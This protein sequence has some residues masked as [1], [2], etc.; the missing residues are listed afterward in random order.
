MPNP[1]PSLDDLKRQIAQVDALASQGVLSAP[2]A[3]EARAKL[4]K[5]L[6]EAVTA[7]P[8][9]AP[10][11]AA[12]VPTAPA[13]EAAPRTPRRL[14]VGVAAFVVVFA[15]AGYAWR[16]N[17]EGWSVGP[18][19]TSTA[20]AGQ[21]SHTVTTEQIAAMVGK[22]EER[23]KTQPDDADGWSMLGRT[24]TALNRRDEAL[25]AFRKVVALRPQDAQALAD[26]ADALAVMNGRSLDGEPEKLIQQAVKLDPAN[27][28]ALALAGTI[29]FNRDD[30]KTA[31][32]YW[33]R[34]VDRS[35]PG[36]DFA[37]QLQGAVA[38]ARQRAGMAPVA[39]AAAAA[40]APSTAAASGSA[41]SVVAGAAITGRVTLSAALKDKVAPG[42]S[43]FIFARPAT[44]ARMPLAILR[45]QAGEL[46]L[47]FK[48]DDSLAMSP[49]A[50]LS[51][52][53]QVI[54]GARISK[55]G[56]AMPQ[57]GDLQGLSQ[58]VAVGAQGVTIEIAETVK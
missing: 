47:E 16:G 10:G 34:A 28:K 53:Q 56:N 50:R 18:G 48:L 17:H 22:L 33:Q 38:E 7:V 45:K 35:E 49:A 55:S 41:G 46:P 15:A 52:A 40:T 9:P 30:F 4:E 23:L 32:D 14:A 39:A 3:A 44:G 20:A 24:Y 8:A 31:V 36:S 29:A 43:L 12:A 37:Q 58:P 1:T 51:T 11:A 2:A 25:A 13:A 6:V 5:Q 42:D 27:V 19:D 21:G 26:L 57:P 54:V